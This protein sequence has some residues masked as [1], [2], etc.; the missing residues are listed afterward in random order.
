MK[1]DPNE[2]KGLEGHS[3]LL[4]DFRKA[5]KA[6]G[7]TIVNDGV[8]GG[9]SKGSIGIDEQGN[10][11]FRGT[12]SL[13]N[14]GG[15]SLARLALEPVSAKGHRAISL[16][17]QGDGKKYQ[18]RLKSRKGQMHSYTRRF[19]TSGEW[20]RIEIPF[21][22]LKPTFRGNKLDLPGYPADQIEEIG[23]LIGNK[24]QEEFK[25]AIRSIGLE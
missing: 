7:W 17:L 13:E 18:I 24:K 5:G 21:E 1:A 19:E 14:N 6:N 15:F 20:E 25:L 12:V 9:L 16:V 4:Y 23:L 22:D 10:G 8:M 2:M 3:Q 11:I